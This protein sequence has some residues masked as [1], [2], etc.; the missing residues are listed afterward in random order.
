VKQWQRYLAELFGTFVLVFGGTTGILAAL[1][2]VDAAPWNVAGG[3]G[4]NAVELIVPFAF[5]LALMAGLYTFAEV[6]GGHFNPAVSLGLFLDRRLTFEDLLGYWIFQFAGAIL[7]SLLMLIP[8]NHDLVK[9]TATQPGVGI[10]QGAALFIEIAFTAVFVLVILHSTK[11]DR[12]GGTALMAIP[13]TL[14]AIHFA[15]LPISG[16]SVNPARSLGPAL[17]GDQWHAFW[18]SVVGPAAGAIIAWIIYTVVIKGD[19]DFRDDLQGL[20]RE[21]KPPS[22][23]PPA[24]AGDAAPPAS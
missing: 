10:S 23:T 18:I 8:F 24:S 22:S 1:R 6:S 2:V 5:G 3:S 12:F 14:V 13:L 4:S 19:T 16:S 20:R 9:A 7:A 21:V 15:A 17:V 11:S